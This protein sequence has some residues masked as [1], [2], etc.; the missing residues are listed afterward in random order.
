MTKIVASGFI[1]RCA[2]GEP[3]A[4]EAVVVGEGGEFVPIVVHRVDF[5]LVGPGQAAF[6]LKVIGRVGEDQIDAGLGQAAHG[7]DAVA[8]QD[9]VQRRL[10]AA[11]RART[12]FGREPA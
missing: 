12:A 6:E 3:V 9:L 1:A 2:A 11:R 7:L 5:A 4:G 10:E 8:D